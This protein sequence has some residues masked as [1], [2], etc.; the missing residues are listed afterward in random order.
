MSEAEPWFSVRCLFSHSSQADPDDGNLY[1]E[2]ITLWKSE[3]WDEAYRLAKEEALKYARESGA[4][5]IE[6][7]DSFHLFGKDQESGAEVWSLMRGSQLDPENYRDSF[8]CTNR[9]RAQ[10]E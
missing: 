3:T 10:E 9:E 7:T 8:L 2:R 6:A 4:E 5:F 1:E